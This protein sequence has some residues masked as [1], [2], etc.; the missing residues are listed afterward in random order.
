[1]IY[2]SITTCQRFWNFALTMLCLQHAVRPP[3]LF[4]HVLDDRRSGP[5][6]GWKDALLKHLQGRHVVQCVEYLDIEEGLPPHARYNAA[7]ARIIQSVCESSASLWIHLD[8]DLC[9]A[10]DLL[11]RGVADYQRWMEHG[12]LYLFTNRWGNVAREHFRGPLWRVHELGGCA[13]IASRASLLAIDVPFATRA[14]Q[15]LPHEQLW[16]AFRSADLPLLCNREFPYPVQHTA[17]AESLLF[18]QQETWREGWQMHLLTGAPVDVPPFGF[19]ALRQAVNDHRL[20]QL[21]REWNE[22]LRTDVRLPTDDR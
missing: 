17:N 9:F 15:L 12:V 10:G 1:L 16:E 6:Q 8:D 3:E 14:A 2:L 21:V 22:R 5:E 18:G 7:F 19:D 4:V 13:F 20:E 11:V